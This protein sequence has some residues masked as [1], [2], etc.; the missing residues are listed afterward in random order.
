M[1]RQFA[2]ENFGNV[3]LVVNGSVKHIGIKQ[4]LEK[5]SSVSH[6]N[7]RGFIIMVCDKT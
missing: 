3:K 4:T 6:V 7:E 5:M 2:R 1:A